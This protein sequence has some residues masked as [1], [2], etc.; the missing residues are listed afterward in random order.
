[1]LLVKLVVHISISDANRQLWA[2]FPFLAVMNYL[3]GGNEVS[4]SFAWCVCCV[5]CE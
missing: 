2:V 3:V 1:M 4:G 5:A